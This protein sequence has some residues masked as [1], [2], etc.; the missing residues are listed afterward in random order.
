MIYSAGAITPTDWWDTSEP[1]TTVSGANIGASYGIGFNN[2]TKF[3]YTIDTILLITKTN[4]E[5]T[6]ITNFGS[7]GSGANQFFDSQGLCY[8]ES[9]DYLYIAD[10]GNNRIVKT[11]IDGTGWTEYKPTGGDALAYPSAVFYDNINDFIYIC[12]CATTIYEVDRIIKVKMN[13]TSR[14]NFGTTGNG[15]N[16]FNQPYSIFVDVLTGYIYIAD[17]DNNRIVKTKI[18][19]TG[20]TTFGSY[21]TGTNQFSFHQGLFYNSS[22]EYL[23]IADSGNNRIVKTKIDG[24][25]WTTFG[26]V[27][28]GT[29]QFILPTSLI[30]DNSSQYI[31]TTDSANAR[32]V[33]FPEGKFA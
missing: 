32:I 33:R 2:S 18:D 12:D 20:W 3:I 9:T 23:Y 14:T 31:Y 27:G 22:T 13:G 25:G 11:K 4:I 29:N 7:I 24:T 21:G 5:G 28:S 8:D 1:W 17:K 19:G 6:S 16:E 10:S 30:L 26:S 15:I